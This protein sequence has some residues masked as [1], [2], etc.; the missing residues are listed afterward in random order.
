MST[1]AGE[2]AHPRKTFPRALLIAVGL[3]VVMYLGPLMVGLG[4]TVKIADWELGYFTT[5][6]QMVR[7]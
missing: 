2:V 7:R 5:V 6:A 1:L 4:V 3:V